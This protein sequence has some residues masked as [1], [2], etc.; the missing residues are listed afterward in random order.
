MI[1]HCSQASIA[2]A[3]SRSRLRRPAWVRRV[4][5]GERRL[6]HLHRL[7]RNVVEARVLERREQEFDVGR[8]FLSPD[9]GGDGQGRAFAR[10]GGEPALELS[11]AAVEKQ[12]P[13]AGCKSQHVDQIVR[14]IRR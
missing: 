8:R 12:H 11:V 14:L 4:R 1:P 9:L 13:G 10:G 5:T 2:L 3:S 7:L 6:P